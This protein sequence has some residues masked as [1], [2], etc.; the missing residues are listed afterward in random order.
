MKIAYIDIIHDQ[1]FKPGLIMTTQLKEQEAKTIIFLHLPKAAGTTLRDIFSRQYQAD[2]I[3]ELDGTKFLK[4]QEDFKQLE[5]EKKEKIRILMGHMYFGLHEFLPGPTTYVTMLRNPIERVISYY[6]FVKNLPTHPDYELIKSKK[7]TLADYC[8]M[9]RE[10]M[11]N[12]QTRFLSGTKEFEACSYQTLEQAKKHLQENFSAV[13]IQEKFDESLLL[14]KS[15]LNWQKTPFYYQRNTNKANFYDQLEISNKTLS[16]IEK[17]NEL[18]LELYEYANKMFE[19]EYNQ[20]SHKINQNLQ[21]F[22]L[23]NQI[24]GKYSVFIKKVA[25]SKMSA[26][27]SHKA[28]FL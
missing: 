22:K 21:L 3:Y 14:L 6:F 7:I 4:A 9:Q 28:I 11:R 24:Y 8:R 5:V 10:N 18:D 16:T 27:A 12:G 23:T 19:Q 1:T 2:S 15:K 17:S 20:Q 13:G 25:S 26:L